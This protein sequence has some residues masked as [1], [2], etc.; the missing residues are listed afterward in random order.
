MSGFNNEKIVSYNFDLNGKTYL[1]YKNRISEYDALGNYVKD[2]FIKVKNRSLSGL[3]LVVQNLGG[4]N[5][6]SVHVLDRFDRNL[7]YNVSLSTVT[8]I[9]EN[10]NKVYNLSGS[11]LVDNIYD[12]SNYNYQQGIILSNSPIPS[13]RF[14]L[15][16]FN[17]L[18]YEDAKI[19][20]HN[21]LG[22]YLNTGEHHFAI[23]LNTIQGEYNLYIDGK[24]FSKKTFLPKK[25]SFTKLLTDTILAG[26][27]LFY[28]GILFS[29]FYE[30]EK[31][32]LFVNDFKLE[33][34]KI[35]NECLSPEEVRLLYFQKYPPKDISIS[36]PIGERNYLDTITRT[37][38]HK[39][40]G[41]KSNLINLYINDSLITDKSIQKIYELKILNEI[42]R[43]IPSYIKI[44]SITW[45]NNKEGDEKM[46]EGNFNVRNTVT[47]TL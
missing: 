9:D 44:N 13:Y 34:F 14:I 45:L 22:E 43:V 46:I 24:L 20:T 3:N 32:F 36:V 40:Q 10:Y 33:K 37:F 18:N 8:L 21:V 17:Q 27:T 47:D 35:Y 41:S 29:D 38:K 42:K 7:M 12:I 23:T 2:W 16:L 11:N 6:I 15:K 28:G 30:A 39:M 5:E 4:K 19:L 31:D 25:Y 1:L 26:A